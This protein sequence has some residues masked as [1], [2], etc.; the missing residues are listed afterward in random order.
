MISYPSI[1]SSLKIII[2]S[3]IFLGLL[4][5]PTAL[6]AQEDSPY[7]APADKNY[8]EGYIVK[9][10]ERFFR[11]CEH[12]PL[13]F[14]QSRGSSPAFDYKRLVLFRNHPTIQGYLSRN[15]ETEILNFNPNIEETR[16]TFLLKNQPPQLN[17]IKISE[18]EL[19]GIDYDVFGGKYN[20]NG[21]VYQQ[22]NLP[23][24]T[25]I[26][27]RNRVEQDVQSH[28]VHC[29]GD[30]TKETS[31]QYY[32]TIYVPYSLDPGLII[33]QGINSAKTDDR[34]KAE[35]EKLP[36]I[37]QE[38]DQFYQAIDVTDDLEDLAHLP[39]VEP[40]QSGQKKAN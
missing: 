30:P 5:P 23:N 11:I 28:F 38:I 19:S 10:S 8:P 34:G 26:I 13:T 33:V 39:I 6:I 3:A 25:F 7:C 14:R 21:K 31:S 9:L 40:R 24:G 29:N 36:S 1:I 27:H 32:C 18:I 17:N 35:F 15:G 4:I 2:R 16:P 22:G 20:N 12:E 37:V